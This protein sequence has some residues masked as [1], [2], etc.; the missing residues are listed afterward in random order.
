MAVGEIVAGLKLVSEGV[1]AIA[2]IADTTQ[3]AEVKKVT[4][5]MGNHVLS[6][7]TQLLDLVNENAAL[8]QENF[9][10]K[11]RLELRVK[12]IHKSPFFFLEGED[13]PLCP[14]CWQE[15]NKPFYLI[16]RSWSGGRSYSCPSHIC[17]FT[18]EEGGGLGRSMP[19]W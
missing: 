13:K 11:A 18:H 3:N 6:L 17:G 19:G 5:D 12:V 9:D 10:L 4:I 15:R 14:T 8:K 2:G 16:F 1:K 7:Q